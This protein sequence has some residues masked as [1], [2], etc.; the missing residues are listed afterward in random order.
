MTGPYALLDVP[1]YDGRETGSKLQAQARSPSRL[2]V[3]EWP[4]TVTRRRQGGA[5]HYRK[6]REM[7]TK[8]QTGKGLPN[9]L[10]NQGQDKGLLSPAIQGVLGAPGKTQGLDRMAQERP[11]E[12]GRWHFW[13][14]RVP[15]RLFQRRLAR[16]AGGERMPQRTS[17]AREMLPWVGWFGG[18]DGFGARYAVVRCM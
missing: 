13:Q 3:V 8:S 11:G 18:P 6:D 12:I 9:C 16:G 15:R 14:F 17:Q 2:E 1:R 7:P 5:I 10:S 4:H